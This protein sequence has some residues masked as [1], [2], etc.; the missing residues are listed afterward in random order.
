MIEMLDANYPVSVACRVLRCARSSYYHQSAEPDETELEAAIEAVV[1]DWPTYGSR[2]V[3]AQLRRQEWTI[4]RKRIQRLMR[5]MGLQVKIKRIF[6]ISR[7][8]HFVICH[9][10]H[11]DT[12]NAEKNKKTL[13]PPCL[14]GKNRPGI[15]R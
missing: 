13:R 9:P 7:G 12:E 6:S 10:H 14:R 2:R 4:N 8:K 1:A 15:L 3:T 5:Q 11:R